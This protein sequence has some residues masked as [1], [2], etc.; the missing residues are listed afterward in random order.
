MLAQTFLSFSYF[1]AAVFHFFKIF[2]EKALTLFVHFWTSYSLFNPLQS[3]FSLASVLST[4]LR[5]LLWW[6]SPRSSQF[7]NLMNVTSFDTIDTLD[8]IPFISMFP[9]SYSYLLF[10]SIFL[11]SHILYIC[12]FTEFPRPTA[13]LTSKIHLF[14]RH[15]WPCTCWFLNLLF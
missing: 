10:I 12:C 11:S 8:T 3:G 13:L 6:R 9:Y 15:Q 14:L 2:K 7:P 1:K 4:Q 5:V